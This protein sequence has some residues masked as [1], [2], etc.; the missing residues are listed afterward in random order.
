M[1]K[2]ALYSNTANGMQFSTRDQD[3]DRVT[4]RH[5]AKRHGYGGNWYNACHLQNLNGKYQVAKDALC[6]FVWSLF[7][8]FGARARCT[9]SVGD[10][11]SQL[12]RSK[13]MIRPKK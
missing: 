3:N 5:C 11:S 13:M 1:G 7:R 8:T 9:D 2:D 10:R 4:N 12:K 6:T